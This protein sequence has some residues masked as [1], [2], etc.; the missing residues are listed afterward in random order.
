[1]LGDAGAAG[2]VSV[3]REG[4]NVNG[5]RDPRDRRLPA[6]RLHTEE[7]EGDGVLGLEATWTIKAQRE[8]QLYHLRAS[9][10]YK[11]Y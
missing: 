9:G 11:I 10:M 1:M 7:R 8:R 3:G 2:Q 5:R 4:A 6:Q